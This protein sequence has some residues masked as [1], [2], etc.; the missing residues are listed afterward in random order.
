MFESIEAGHPHAYGVSERQ[1]RIQTFAPL[2]SAA[3]SR[4]R[5]RYSSHEQLR[6]R[7]PELRR[8]PGDRRR[9]A[10][11]RRAPA[12]R[13]D[14]LGDRVLPRDVRSLLP[15]RRPG[16]IAGLDS[17]FFSGWARTG[18]S[19]LGPRAGKLRSRAGAAGL[20]VLRLAVG[21]PRLAFLFGEPGRVLPGQPVIRRAMAGRGRQ[22]LPGGPA[23]AGDG[24]VPGRHGSGLP[25]LQPTRLT[26]TTATRPSPR[27]GRRWKR[28]A[29][30]AKAMVPMRR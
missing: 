19:F 1:F 18:E 27:S 30:S 5:S 22:R 15:V 16:E 17:G 26:R 23:S 6:G 28:S 10:R 8:V 9:S 2:S 21:G 4:T 29:G 25:G 24:S 7:V 12:T 11:A 13:R 3:T 20:P 14:D